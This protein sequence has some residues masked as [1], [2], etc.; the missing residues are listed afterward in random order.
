MTRKH[1][2]NAK[3]HNELGWQFFL[4]VT[5]IIILNYMHVCMSMY[6]CVQ[7]SPETRRGHWTLELELEAV[8]SCQILGLGITLWS[9][10]MQSSLLTPI[11]LSISL[12]PRLGFLLLS[13]HYMVHVVSGAKATKWSSV[14]ST[15]EMRCSV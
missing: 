13:T 2:T 10:A 9:F 1:G 11:H 4:R 7:V 3:G 6:R 8:M 15:F 12:Y 14:I 5:F